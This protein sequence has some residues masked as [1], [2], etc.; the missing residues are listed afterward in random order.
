[1]QHF[2]VLRLSLQE[3]LQS[4]LVI[5]GFA[6]LLLPFVG[7]VYYLVSHLGSVAENA[8]LTDLYTLCAKA[9]GGGLDE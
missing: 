9:T 5:L 1:M 7:G 2:V 4:P 8:A 6:L 3:K